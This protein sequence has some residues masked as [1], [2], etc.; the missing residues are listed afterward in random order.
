MFN[1]KRLMAVLLVAGTASIFCYAQNSVT[2]TK[3]ETETTV[4]ENNENLTDAQ[5]AQ[6]EIVFEDSEGN[7]TSVIQNGGT[8]GIFV[9]LR[10]I[11]V[12]AIVV[13][14]IYLAFRF[15]KKTV[16]PTGEK[17][18]FLRKV[19]S[20][21]LAVGKSVQIV[22]LI[23]KAY[24]IGV[25]DNGVNLIDKIDDKELINAMNLYADKMDSTSKPKNFAE[26]LEL[27]MPSKENV[28]SSSSDMSA[29]SGTGAKSKLNSLFGKKSAYDADTMELINSLKNKRMNGGE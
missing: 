12:L 21:P 25:S 26:V 10:M 29:A 17:D 16:N 4:Q 22:T 7:D 5:K 27:F 9:F 18:P 3:S 11:L 19:S 28:K 23:D 20:V 13:G 6:N 15:F 2:E 8:S 1:L 14:A 24:M